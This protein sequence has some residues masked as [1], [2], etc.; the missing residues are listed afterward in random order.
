M[1]VIAFLGIAFAI[2]FTRCFTIFHE[3]FFT[4]DLWI[5][6]EATDYMIRMLPEG[7]FSDM[8]LRIGTAFIGMLI[9]L[10]AGFIGWKRVSLKKEKC[11]D[12][13]L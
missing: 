11:C 7:F 13:D 1:V 10:W 2:D 8:V 3:I 12:G 9:V 5:F 6:D 4:N